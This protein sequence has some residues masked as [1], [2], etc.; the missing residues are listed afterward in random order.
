MPWS[1]ASIVCSVCAILCFVSLFTISNTIQDADAFGQMIEAEERK[2]VRQ[3]EY[4]SPTDIDR[5]KSISRQLAAVQATKNMPDET[6]YTHTKIISILVIVNSIICIFVFQHLVSISTFIPC[7]SNNSVIEDAVNKWKR[8]RQEWKN[9]TDGKNEAKNAMD[10]AKQTM[11]DLKSKSKT[12]WDIQTIAI[13]AA[14]TNIGLFIWLCFH[15]YNL[16]RWEKKVPS[17]IR[18]IVCEERERLDGQTCVCNT[19]FERVGTACVAVCSASQVRDAA[20][21]CVA[22]PTCGVNEELRG[23]VCECKSDFERVGTACVAACSADQVRDAAGACVA[24]PTCG[25]NEELRGAV[26]ECKSGFRREGTACVA[27]PTQSASA[28]VDDDVHVIGFSDVSYLSLMMKH[29]LL[30]GFVFFVFT[31]SSVIV[32]TRITRKRAWCFGP[33][34]GKNNASY[35]SAPAFEIS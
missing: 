4:T 11:D 12:V 7:T 26:C 32:S 1:V 15:M 10:G 31:V 19:G 17:F 30:G 34:Y 24:R 2:L 20:G 13:L 27:D 9:K 6:I 21:A 5:K 33:V 16:W 29:L 25:T 22:R 14:V 35:T 28:G 23:A 8:A 18:R 3:M